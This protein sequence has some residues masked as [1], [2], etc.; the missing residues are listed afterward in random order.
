MATLLKASV[1]SQDERELISRLSGKIRKEQKRLGNLNDYFEAEQKLQHIGLAV[2]PELR[3]FEAIINVP[4]MAA[5]EPALRQN[6][7]GFYRQ[8]Q[9][10]TKPE[11][12]LSEA[13]NFNNLASQSSILQIE[14]KVYGRSFTSVSSNAEDPDH[15]LI[16]VEDPRAIAWTIDPLYRRFREVLRIYRDAD[17]G[18]TRGTLMLPDETLHVHKGRGG[19]WE[20]TDELGYGRDQHKLGAVPVVMFLNRVRSGE[21]CGRS[22]MSDVIGKVD[23]ISRML[24]VLAVGV[25]S[26]GLPSLFVS[27]ASRDDFVDRDGKQIPVWESYLTAIKA[28]QN[29][30]AKVQ[31]IVAGD[32]KNITGAINEMLAWCAAE[33]GLPV[34]YMGNQT[35]NPATEGAI[36][37]DQD[38]LI[39]NVEWKNRFDGDSWSHTMALEERFRTGEWGPKNSIRA[40]YF[41]PATPTYSQRADALTKMHAEGVLS[42]RGF[43]EELG[44]SNARIDMEIQRLDEER[45]DSTTTAILEAM[46]NVAAGDNGVVQ[47]AAVASV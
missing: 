12:A 28:L 20:L 30:D 39:S 21:W 47:E 22:E 24:S 19:R 9:I 7:R 27:G 46:N 37:A 17:L 13:W 41:D 16:R 3:M 29:S 43:L 14:E 11:P 42:R 5:T 31:Q 1:L 23:A 6:L 33:L 34:R 18:V 10:E 45:Q 40:I 26:V 4:R 15:P 2:P 38:R 8:G 25:E 35:V 44:W 36:R 32:L